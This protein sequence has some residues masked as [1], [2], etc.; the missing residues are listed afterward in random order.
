MLS[1]PFPAVHEKDETSFTRLLQCDALPF[2]FIALPF[3]LLE[4]KICPEVAQPLKPACHK[5]LMALQKAFKAFSENDFFLFIYFSESFL[6]MF[7]L[8]I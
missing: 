2:D 5:Q 8:K 3:L 1:Q 7:L 4:N 6:K